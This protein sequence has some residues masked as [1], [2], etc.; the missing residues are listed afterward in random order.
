[1]RALASVRPAESSPPNGLVVVPMPTPPLP[2]TVKSEA[3]VVEAM[4]KRERPPLCCELLVTESFAHGVDV[5]M[6]TLPLP[7]TSKIF[8]PVVDMR[9]ACGR[10]GSGRL[11]A[12]R[13]PRLSRLQGGGFF[14]REDKGLRQHYKQ[15]GGGVE[16]RV[17]GDSGAP[18]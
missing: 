11:R 17:K 16:V 18:I 1:M 8:A 12:A 10:G 13:K 15:Q 2:S 6:P 4:E 14:K 7:R 5:P 3:P 9:R